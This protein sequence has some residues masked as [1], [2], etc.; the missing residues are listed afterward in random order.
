[1]IKNLKNILLLTQGFK[2]SEIII[3][4]FLMLLSSL[5]EAISIGALIPFL[6]ILVNTSSIENYQFLNNSIN[7]FF[8]D[9]NLDRNIITFIS[10]VF[11]S[12][13]IIAASIR[14]YSLNKI[15]RFSHSVGEKLANNIIKDVFNRPLE[16]FFVV[17]TNKIIDGLTIKVNRVVHLINAI[18]VSIN[19][20]AII[21]LII[22]VLIFSSPMVASFSLVFF[23]FIYI[24]IA[25]IVSKTVRLRGAKVIPRYYGNGKNCSRRNRRYKRF[26][27]TW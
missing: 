13:I 15:T 11:A 21:L 24:V 5:S 7:L 22:F 14:F 3:L 16:Y 12:S 23:G 27:I 2:K 20:V 18:L 9:S 26:N 8:E 4:L 19:A 17:N 10:V 1:M 25:K 6:A